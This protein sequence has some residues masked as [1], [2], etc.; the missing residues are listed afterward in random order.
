MEPEHNLM[1]CPHCD[2]LHHFAPLAPNARARC[3]RCRSVLAT[4]RSNAI[5]HVLALAF[6]ATVLMIAT[7]FFPFLT[8]QVGATSNQTSI[9]D[10]F[11]AFADGLLFPLAVAVAC[12]I[13]ILP[14]IRFAA[15]IYALFPLV[16][17]R[18]PFRRA[19]GVFRMAEALK[20][21]SMVE[22]F[23]VGV[24]VSMVK[25]AGL[26]S[27]TFGPAAWALGMLVLITALKDNLICK[28]TIWA[29][30]ERT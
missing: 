6:A 18:P 12:L 15:L 9:F 20:P 8:I 2:T 28:W 13:V 17:G 14:L 7:L 5:S 22:I 23:V 25:I 29:A 16:V 27:I 26:A 24:A 10:A 21:W 30:L 3:V 1:A 11:M 4:N 19:S